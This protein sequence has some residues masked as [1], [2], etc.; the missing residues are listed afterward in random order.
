METL[1]E[2]IQ[3]LYPSQ[4]LDLKAVATMHVLGLTGTPEGKEVIFKVPEVVRLLFQ[5][6][7]DS[8][9]SVAK[10]AVL[11]LINLTSEEE[12]ANK[13]FQEASKM[14]PVSFSFIYFSQ[15]KKLIN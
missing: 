1:Q 8:A 7:E 3:F 13:I 6:S 10:D 15:K 11:A 14:D 9:E 4:R 12:D 5:L 2:L